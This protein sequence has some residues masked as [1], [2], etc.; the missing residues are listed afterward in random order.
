M[1][2]SDFE[3]LVS[4][5]VIFKREGRFIGREGNLRVHYF[6]DL[7]SAAHSQDDLESLSS[8]FAT[9]IAKYRNINE[10]E[11]IAAPKRGNPLLARA[12]GPL[13]GLA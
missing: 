1:D 12:S 8:V 3:A 11:T 5:Y 7:A 4:K 10:I 6:L 13:P 2:Q 9:F